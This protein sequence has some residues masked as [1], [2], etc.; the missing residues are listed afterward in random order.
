MAKK[1]VYVSLDYKHDKYYKYLLESWDA[2]PGFK[3]VFGD[4][5][6]D[7]IVPDNIDR[8]KAGLTKKINGTSYTLVIIGIEANTSDPDETLI[9][10]KNWINFEVHQ[11]KLHHN[12]HIGVKLKESYE[13]PAELQGTAAKITS[14][15]NLDE[16]AN[17]L[18][19]P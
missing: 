9:G 14:R 19:E 13:S 11:S 15:F 3:F 16:I 8:I 4:E 12:K 5:P 17:L 7:Y 2:N 6:P 1:K 10:F 18:R